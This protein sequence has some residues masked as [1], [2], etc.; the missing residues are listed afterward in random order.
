VAEGITLFQGIYNPERLRYIHRNFLRSK[1]CSDFTPGEIIAKTACFFSKNLDVYID[2]SDGVNDDLGIQEYAGRMLSCIKVSNGKRFL[3]LKCA[4]SPLWSKDITELAE[5]NNGTVEPFFKFS[6]NKNFY[7]FLY[8]NIKD[9]RKKNME[10]VPDFD[11]GIFADLKKVYSYPKPSISDPRVS[12]SD[13]KKFNISGASHDTGMLVVNSR[14]F[15]LEKLQD[16]NFKMLIEHADY[17]DYISSSIK[18]K[19]VIN[20]PGIGEYTSRMMDQTAIGN[21]IILRKNSYDQAASWKEF[22]PEVDFS[23]ENYKDELQDILENCALW[24]EKS[25]YYYD[26]FWTPDA[27]FNHLATRVKEVL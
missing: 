27:V 13:H 23:S 10:T 7:K 5:K 20:P 17:A 1:L 15:V 4:H 22:I 2:T 11:L 21:L 25:R 26:T 12:W 14:S 16:T 9:L 18:C 24:Q 3:Y 6:F 8:P 19:A